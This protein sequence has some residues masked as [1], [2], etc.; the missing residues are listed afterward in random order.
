MTWLESLMSPLKYNFFFG[1]LH[2]SQDKTIYRGKAIYRGETE[3][4]DKVFPTY[5]PKWIFTN[6]VYPVKIDKTSKNNWAYIVYIKDAY[7]RTVTWI[8]YGSKHA[9][10]KYWQF[11]SLPWNRVESQ[12]SADTLALE[13][14]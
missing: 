6:G 12:S 10:L 4:Y 8:P 3:L 5:Q 14:V 1:G 7:D 2:L 11:S 13:C 9:L